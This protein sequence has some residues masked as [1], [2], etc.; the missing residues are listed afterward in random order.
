MATLT[1]AERALIDKA[2]KGSFEA[3]EVQS[4]LPAILLKVVDAVDAGSG[5]GIPAITDPV[6]GNLPLMDANGNLVT[7]A[8]KPADFATSSQ[9][10]KADTALQP[11]AASTGKVAV[12]KADGTL[13]GGPLASGILRTIVLS[14]DHVPNGAEDTATTLPAGAVVTDA[15]LIVNTAAGT[16]VTLKVG[17]NGNTDAFLGGCSTGACPV[18]A[19]AGYEQSPILDGTSAW[20]DKCYGGGDL[21]TFIQGASADDRGAHFRKVAGTPVVGGKK[22]ALEGSAAD[23]DFRGT[24]LVTYFEAA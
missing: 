13:E 18:D 20:L 23:T 7:G 10:G 22:I 14:L 15:L 17:V 9:G 4:Q 12:V 1:A 6:A 3:P 21:S 11:V 19:Q 2:T 8:S 5:G 16:G 24:L